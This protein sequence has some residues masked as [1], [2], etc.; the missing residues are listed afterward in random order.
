MLLRIWSLPLV[1]VSKF[2]EIVSR[3]GSGSGWEKA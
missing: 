2:A 1:R 3:L